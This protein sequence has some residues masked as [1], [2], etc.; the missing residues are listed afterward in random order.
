MAKRDGI[1]SALFFAKSWLDMVVI[2]DYDAGNLRSVQRA[3]HQVGIE[4][5]ISAD[6]DTVRRADR[7]IFP[8]VGAAGSAMASLQAS[9]MD[10]ALREVVAAGKPVFGICLGL[11]ISLE[12]SE[13]NE[14]P[15]SACWRGRW[16]A[17]GRALLS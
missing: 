13:E 9:G 14:K 17:F 16:C 11:Q 15:R 5:E 1:V 8:G 3:C 7:I 4:A 12:R 2:V 6:P 10:A